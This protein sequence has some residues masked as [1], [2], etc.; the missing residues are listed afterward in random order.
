[1][2]GEGIFLYFMLFFSAG[3]ICW[4]LGLRFKEL[5]EEIKELKEEIKKLKENV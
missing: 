5:D 1:M 4:G 3:I 2:S